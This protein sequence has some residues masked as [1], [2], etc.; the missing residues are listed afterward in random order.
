MLMI[1]LDDIVFCYPDGEFTL[2]I[3]ELR[4]DSG[5][6]VAIIGPSGSGKTTLLHLLAAIV[7]PGQGRIVVDNVVVSE[8]GDAARRRFRIERMGLVFQEFALLE[9]LNVIDNVLLP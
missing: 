4:I 1:E 6:R 8:L 7:L 3:P 5:A 9:H 2:R